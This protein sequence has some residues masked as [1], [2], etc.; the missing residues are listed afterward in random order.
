MSV[1]FQKENVLCFQS[2]NLH[3]PTVPKRLKKL[4]KIDESDEC[5]LTS[6]NIELITY[7]SLLS[8]HAQKSNSEQFTRD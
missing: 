3:I 5:S 6:S 8:R 7:T 4:E 1:S 2:N